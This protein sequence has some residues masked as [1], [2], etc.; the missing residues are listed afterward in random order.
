LTNATD[1]ADVTDVARVPVAHTAVA[2]HITAAQRTTT[3]VA[4]TDNQHQDPDDQRCPQPL[5][6]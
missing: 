4:G 2:Q 6:C 1:V 5:L 3:T